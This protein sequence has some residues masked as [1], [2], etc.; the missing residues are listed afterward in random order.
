MILFQILSLPSPFSD[1][2]VHMVH[3]NKERETLPAPTKIQV[4]LMKLNGKRNG[5]G[6][7]NERSLH[8]ICKQISPSSCLVISLDLTSTKQLILDANKSWQKSS[9]FQF[10]LCKRK[11]CAFVEALTAKLRD[12]LRSWFLEMLLLLLLVCVCFLMHYFD[13]LRDRKSVV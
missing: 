9:F 6:R 13:T 4:F 8:F 2:I 10:C 3:K 5:L 11:N 1:V 12:Q 7:E